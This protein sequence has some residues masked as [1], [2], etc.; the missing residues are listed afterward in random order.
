MAGNTLEWLNNIFSS[1]PQRHSR[2]YQKNEEDKL[3]VRPDDCSLSLDWTRTSE[4]YISHIPEKL[5]T[6][7]ENKEKGAATLSLEIG[8]PLRIPTEKQKED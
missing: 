5:R 1:A 4:G 2:W 7:L 3:E 6:L 8:D